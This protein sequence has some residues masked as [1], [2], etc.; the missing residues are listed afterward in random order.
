MLEDQET[1]G[2]FVLLLASYDEIEVLKDVKD[3]Q[4]K[5]NMS[6][7]QDWWLMNRTYL[8]NFWIL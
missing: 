8:L 1:K 5:K 4:R 6:T 7:K 3:W 2:T